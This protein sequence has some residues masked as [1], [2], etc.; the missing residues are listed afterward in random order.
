MSASALPWSA[1]E[2]T[3]APHPY[4]LPESTATHLHLDLGV[5]GLG[6][7]S[8]GQG[9]PLEP[10]RVK[11][12]NHSMSFIIRP[13][14]RASYIETANIAASGE[15]PISISRDRKGMVTISSRKTGAP[16]VYM[17]NDSKKGQIYTEPFDMREGGVVTAYYTENKAI[18]A[19][20]A[21]DK[22]EYIPMEVVYVSSQET[23]VGNVAH[24]VD[25]DPDT[26]WQTMHSVT[27]AKYP[28]WVD[29]DAGEVKNVKGFIYLSRQDRKLNGS[30]KEYSLQVSLDGK[31]WGD[32]VATGSFEKSKKPQR[33]MLNNPVKARY[34]RFTGLS[35]Q[36]GSDFAGGAEFSVIAD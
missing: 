11:A 13:V 19:T 29:F 35:S 34:I 31:N 23:G 32:V 9:S 4:Q 8:C 10:D 6:G 12:D 14:Y 27:V 28:H 1:V 17:L 30:I 15:I 25:G 3:L 24:L 2:L 21:Y 36:N 16:I 7:N 5:T 22:I 26:S 33:V 18:V 20:M